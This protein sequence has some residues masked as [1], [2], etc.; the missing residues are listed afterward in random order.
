M[1]VTFAILPM[2]LNLRFFNTLYFNS[3]YVCQSY[4]FTFVQ[5]FAEVAYDNK[6]MFS[7]I[8]MIKYDTIVILAPKCWQETTCSFI[9]RNN[10]KN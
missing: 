4:F 6:I 9:H 10:E 1:C 5:F 7:V 2:S 8:S 3:L